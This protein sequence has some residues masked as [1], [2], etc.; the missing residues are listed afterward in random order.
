M[1]IVEV[2]RF[3]GMLVRLGRDF[4]LWRF[5]MPADGAALPR[6]SSQPGG[7]EA[8]AVLFPWPHPHKAPPAKAPTQTALDCYFYDL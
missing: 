4:R 8:P 2:G 1:V 6:P 5:V 7:C 3:L